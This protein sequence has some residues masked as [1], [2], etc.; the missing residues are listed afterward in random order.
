MLRLFVDDELT[1][2]DPAF[3]Q[4]Y[5]DDVRAV[6]SDDIMR[7]TKKY[8]VPEDMAFLVVGR[9]GEIEAGDLEGRARMSEFFGGSVTHLPLRDPLTLEPIE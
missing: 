9:W 3:W 5:R 6:T 4:T 8:L 1:G 7:V 2:R